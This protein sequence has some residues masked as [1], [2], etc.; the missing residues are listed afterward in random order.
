MLSWNLESGTWLE[1]KALGYS[2]T[3]FNKGKVGNISDPFLLKQLVGISRSVKGKVFPPEF[4]HDPETGEKLVIEKPL[5]NRVWLAPLG[6]NI[7]QAKQTNN[8]NNGLQFSA[9]LRNLKQPPKEISDAAQKE[10][11]CSKLK[12]AFEFFS[13]YCSTGIPQL[14]AICKNKKELWILTE[15]KTGNDWVNLKA[16]GLALAECPTELIEYWHATTFYDDEKRQHKLYI[17]T[18]LGLA[19]LSV[20][21]FSQTYHVEYLTE[22]GPCL[23]NAIYWREKLL[24][25]I[26]IQNKL[27]VVDALS[28]EPYRLKT[29][30]LGEM[31]FLK[32]VYDL[33]QLIWIGQNGQLIIEVNETQEIH[34]EYL[35]WL[36]SIKPDFRF[37]APYLDRDGYFHQLCDKGD[38]LC[39]VQLSNKVQNAKNTNFRFTTGKTAYYFRNKI[40]GN[41]W[42]EPKG[43]LDDQTIFVPLIENP[44]NELLLG[45]QFESDT[46]EPIRE[47]LD[48]ELQQSIILF[49]DSYAKTTLIHRISVKNPLA[50]RYFYHQ[51]YLYFYNPNLEKLVGWEAE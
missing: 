7:E 23:G 2:L 16:K 21:A 47:K 32:T 20:D 13:I 5:S 4:K 48:S 14:I 36:P 15:N 8:E 50:S 41:I 30:S 10:I 40:E 28:G 33:N 26:L 29:G 18:V 35:P 43:E 22:G 17:P 38:E 1:N 9:Q 12:G 3:E 44:K 11:D 45:F 25:P 19:C 27:E 6:S 31:Y 46:S 34:A 49:L 39:Y 51:D 24:V 42:E 37:G